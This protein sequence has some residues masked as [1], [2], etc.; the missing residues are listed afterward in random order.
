MYPTAKLGNRVLHAL[1]ALAF[2]T[3]LHPT[4]QAQIIQQGAK[5]VGTGAVGAAGQ[6]FSVA[7]SGDGN[8]AIVGAPVDNSVAGATWVYTR[9]GGAWS[10]QGGKLVGTGAV[11]A[12]A[13]HQGISVALSGD[14]NTAIVGGDNDNGYIGAAWVYTRSGGAWSQSGAKLVGTGAVG[15]AHQ[16]FAVT[17]SGDGSTAMV[18]GWSDNSYA[19]GAWVFAISAP[20]IVSGGVAKGASFLPGIAPGTWITIQGANLSAT[21]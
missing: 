21:T 19:G 2:G 11:G 5:L 3:G 15:T 18:G 20:S 17:L 12:V 14:G 4:A 1:L 16:G 9:S 6:G 13:A 8:T 7:L 10:Q